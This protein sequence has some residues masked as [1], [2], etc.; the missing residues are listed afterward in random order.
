MSGELAI[1]MDSDSEGQYEQTGGTATSNRATIGGLGAGR[2]RLTAGT[3]EVRSTLVVGV[4]VSGDG[5]NVSGLGGAVEMTGGSLI[6]GGSETLF[7]TRNAGDKEE[8]ADAFRQTGGSHTIGGTFTLRTIGED[9]VSRFVLGA[10]DS[11]A[12]PTL[13]THTTQIESVGASIEQITGQHVTGS[14][15]VNGGRYLQRAGE[16]VTGDLL[17]GSGGVYDLHGGTLTSGG[18]RNDGEFTQDGGSYVAS[19]DMINNGTYRLQSGSA[20]RSGEPV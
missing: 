10:A 11:P 13:R 16:V 18:V 15:R 9:A 5:T 17:I 12:P 1:A 19:G 2:F 7:N 3:H 8:F 4:S 20:T 6:V 14:L